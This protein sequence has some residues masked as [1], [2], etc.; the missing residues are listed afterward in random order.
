MDIVL[1][2]FDTFLFDRLYAAL[3]PTSIGTTSHA[4]LKDGGASTTFSS[5]REMPTAYHAASQYLQLE[6]SQWA[7]MSAWP[8]DNIYRQAL[9]LYLVTWY[10]VSSS[11]KGVPL[12]VPLGSSVS[13]CTSFAPLSHT[14]SSSTTLLSPIPNTSRTKSASKSNR[15]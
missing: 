2:I 15:P 14:S 7:Y 6:P 1:E 5:V 11:C 13:S 10:V 9:T 3:L 12:T 4:S 8:R